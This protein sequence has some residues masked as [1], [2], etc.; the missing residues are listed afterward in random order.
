VRRKLPRY[1]RRT[2]AGIRAGEALADLQGLCVRYEIRL[3]AS[4]ALIGKTLS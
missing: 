1:Q 3:P 2:L 4:F